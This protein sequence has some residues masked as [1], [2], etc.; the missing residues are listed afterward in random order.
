L[1]AIPPKFFNLQAKPRGMA[2]KRVADRN[3][4]PHAAGAGK[5]FLRFPFAIGA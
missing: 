2:M 5:S 1:R 4:P 3:A